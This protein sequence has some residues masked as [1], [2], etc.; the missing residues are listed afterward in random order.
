MATKASL[1][2]LALSLAGCG[3][4][5]PSDPTT[6]AAIRTTTSFG[7]C[8]GY[9][10]TTLEITSAEAVFV[11]EGWRGEAPIRL[12]TRLT[13]AEW[14]DLAGAVDRRQLE[15]LPAVLGC[16]DCA[17]AGA[18]SLEVVATEWRK[19]VLFDYGAAVPA[20]QPLL[21]KVRIVRR[22]LESTAG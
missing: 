1:F 12:T 16:P 9:C 11:K 13:P 19:D 21:D 5:S 14:R 20:L 2:V 8:V 7:F 17:D 10:R 3:A 4:S 18:E 6:I 22:R 15:A